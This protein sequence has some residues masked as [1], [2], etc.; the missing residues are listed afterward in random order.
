MWPTRHRGWAIATGS[1]PYIGVSVCRRGTSRDVTPPPPW[2][3]SPRA[4]RHR[5]AQPAPGSPRRLKPVNDPTSDKEEVAYVQTAHRDVLQRDRVVGAE[6]D[7]RI[8]ADLMHR[9]LHGPEVC[10]P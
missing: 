3:G 9:G 4:A 5:W 8:G 10:H 7:H 1:S 6:A 2:R